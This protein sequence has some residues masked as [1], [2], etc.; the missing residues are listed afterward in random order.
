MDDDLSLKVKSLA[1]GS[2]VLLVD[3]DEFTLAIYESIFKEMFL[4][5]FTARNGEEA[6]E[7]WMDQNKN[8]DLVVTDVMMPVLDGFELVNKIR[9]QSISQHIIVVTGMND[10][11]E[12]KNI[13]NLGIDGII[14][15]PYD[16]KNFLPVLARVLEVIKAK[17][18]MKR[19]IFQL[20]LLS[21]EQ[22]ALKAT[23][24]AISKSA[25][26]NQLEIAKKDTIVKKKE[27][28]LSTKYNIR[29]TIVGQSAQKT[30]DNIIDESNRND[31]DGLIDSIYDYDA[32]IVT[33][34]KEP[35]ENI[36]DSLVDSTQA[37][38][39]LVDI[40]N[41][42]GS[43]SLAAQAGENLI[44]Y[45]KNFD[46]QKLEDQNKK[47]QFFDTYLSMFQDIEKWLRVVFVDQAAS[48]VNY[49]D[50]SFANT[51]LELET[52]FADDIED[53]SELEFF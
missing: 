15:K 47:E 16:P 49:F 33:L 37:I 11:N 51:C 14:L 32:L 26:F 44:R 28:Q 24:K 31:I 8:I 21:Q 12:M 41:S 29:K 35:I 53:D 18:I 40:M 43:F 34:E 13:I 42:V 36:M 39:N 45:I 9:E 2:S 25:A 17:K 48:N 19:Q 3:D 46:I 50:A 1:R 23:A 10:L 38:E 30:F 20:K 4:R 52:I 27:S 7:L 22:V 5:I 6:Y